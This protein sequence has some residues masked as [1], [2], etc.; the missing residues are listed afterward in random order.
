MVEHVR[1]GV[2][3]G[4]N[5]TCQ[6][7]CS[8]SLNWA[9]HH[10]GITF[11]NYKQCVCLRM[12]HVNTNMFLRRHDQTSG[13]HHRFAW[14]LIMQIFAW[15]LVW[16]T[17]VHLFEGSLASLFKC[18]MCLN[19]QYL[20]YLR[21]QVGLKQHAKL[22]FFRRWLNLADENTQH[23]PNANQKSEHYCID[24]ARDLLFKPRVHVT[25]TTKEHMQQDTQPK[26]T[27]SHTKWLSKQNKTH[28][29][30]KMAQPSATLTKMHPKWPK[31]AHTNK[32]AP[33]MAQK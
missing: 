1:D 28:F 6:T 18:T 12:C 29:A 16:L 23:M 2:A 20:R 5:A 14:C 3:C 21:C 15:R 27:T 22:L 24:V 32:I 30:F 26:V 10:S 7:H 25:D 17:I 33:K 9:V 31:I 13:L 19:V 11:Q 8:K 4:G